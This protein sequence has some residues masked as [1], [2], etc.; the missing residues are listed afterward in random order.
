MN[1][2]KV[3]RVSV[4]MSTYNRSALLSRAIESVHKQAFT[5]WELIITD[6]ASTDGTW[7]ML[8]EY[9]A[10][11]A[12]I[13]PIQNVAENLH[14]VAGILNAG[15]ARACGEYIAR[16][17]DD[18]YWIDVDKLAKQVAYLDAH[19]ECVIVG[20]GVIVMDGADNERY[21]YL[22]AET[23]ME[24]RAGALSSSPF[25]S[26]TVLY[27]KSAA[28]AVGGYEKQYAEDWILWLKIG[29]QGTMYNLQEYSIGYLMAGQNKS[30][31]HQRPHAKTLVGIVVRFRRDYP[32]F[33]HAYAVNLIALLYTYLPAFLHKALYPFASRLK[34]VL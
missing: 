12:R 1:G 18:D 20:T 25:A 8:Q 15:I 14:Y 2:E 16:L 11:D 31:E 5:D 13:K 17:D 9:A 21:R 26:S 22:K 3:P 6:D 30:W 19:P 23:D 27:R 28:L 7:K 33:L 10:K 32:H 34:K 4:V 29:T 24:I